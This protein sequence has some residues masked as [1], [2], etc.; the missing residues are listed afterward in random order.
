MVLR[1]KDNGAI[2]QTV[3]RNCRRQL[4]VGKIVRV[5]GPEETTYDSLDVSIIESSICRANVINVERGYDLSVLE[6]TQQAQ[7]QAD[8]LVLSEA[9]SQPQEEQNDD[10]YEEERLQPEEERA[11]DVTR[12]IPRITMRQTDRNCWEVVLTEEERELINEF[13]DV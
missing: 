11:V 6:R 7:E 8:D 4:R 3:I 10:E 13:L 1:A 9:N 5:T 12:N 2:Y